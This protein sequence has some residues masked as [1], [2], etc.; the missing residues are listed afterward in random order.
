MPKIG[1]KGKDGAGDSSIVISHGAGVKQYVQLVGRGVISVR[2]S[3][4][5]FLWGY[6]PIANGVA[7]IPTPIVQDDYVFCSTGYGTGA[8]LL[9]LSKDGDGVKA[10]EKYFLEPSKLQNHHGGMVLLNGY[11]YCGHSHNE[12]YPICVELESGKV[13]WGGKNDEVTK[14]LPVKN[15]A[16]VLYADGNLIFR[17]QNGDVALIE[18]TPKN[19]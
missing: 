13:V 3:D 6:N 19:T 5:K 11:V 2:A 15:S 10:E 8:A 1:D 7:N 4:G 9:Q 14:I 18:A 17:Y 16:G 12:G